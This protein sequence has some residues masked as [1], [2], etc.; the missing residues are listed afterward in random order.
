MT[1]ARFL[2]IA[3][4]LALVTICIS[5]AGRADVEDVDTTIYWDWVSGSAPFG[6]PNIATVGQTFTVDEETFLSGFAFFVD[7]HY[8]YYGRFLAFGA[9]VMAWDGSRAAGDVLFESGPYITSNNGGEDGFE[10][11]AIDTDELYLPAG[12]YVAFFS[13]SWYFGQPS[14]QS[15]V[16][17]VDGDVYPGGVPVSID[18]GM[19]FDL[20]TEQDWAAYGY[21]ERAF[22]LD[23]TPVPE[24]ATLLLTSILLAWAIAGRLRTLKR[25]K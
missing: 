16:G 11:F 23:F 13:T 21:N 4:T 24:P 8:D 2:R 7:D 19:D 22:W 9:Y 20:V 15:T 1:S 10:E 18:N 25:V 6:V 3:A 17:R 14:V 5:P 12:N